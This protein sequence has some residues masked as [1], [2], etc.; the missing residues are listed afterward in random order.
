MKLVGNTTEQERH[1][2]RCPDCGVK[3][4]KMAHQAGNGG[5]WFCGWMCK[6]VVDPK[7]KEIRPPRMPWIR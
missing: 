5:S 2:P 7:T 6:C 3:M 4:V 1:I